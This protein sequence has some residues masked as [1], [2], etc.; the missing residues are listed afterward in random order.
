MRTVLSPG[1]SPQRHY[2][3]LAPRHMEVPVS[4]HDV[5]ADQDR[6]SDLLSAMQR[7]RGRV[8]LDDGALRRS[9]LT[10]DGRHHLSSDEQSW[11][12]LLLGAQD[13]VLGCMRYLKHRPSLSFSRLGIAKS[14]LAFCNQWGEKFRSAV[15]NQLSRAREEGL[16]FSE[17]GGWALDPEVRG[18]TAA[19]SLVLGIYGLAQLLGPAYGLSTAT[20]RNG[21]ARILQRMGGM[22]LTLGNEELPS[23][24]D[25]HYNCEMQI[26]RFDSRMPAE[27]YRE[28]VAQLRQHLQASSV[29]RGATFAERLIQFGHP[30]PVTDFAVEATA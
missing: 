26:L 3:I 16:G 24:F 8:Y 22:G 19:L 20:T 30:L 17:I 6:Y 21:S 7:L 2:I 18:S 5:V 14:P 27:R 10:F 12:L 25:P 11:H 1:T 28:G 9:D 4:F 29:L 15:V 13:R 23:Y